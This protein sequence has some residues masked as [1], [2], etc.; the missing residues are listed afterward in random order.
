MA[1][2]MLRG[3]RKKKKD[4]QNKWE[5]RRGWRTGGRRLRRADGSLPLTEESCFCACKLDI[6][7]QHFASHRP[8]DVRCMPPPNRPLPFPTIKPNWHCKMSP[9]TKS[10]DTFKH[11]KTHTD[12]KHTQIIPTAT[13]RGSV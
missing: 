5:G 2:K 11:T 8:E 3:G 12:Y 10:R 9:E 1:V 6:S 7:H 4:R 13:T